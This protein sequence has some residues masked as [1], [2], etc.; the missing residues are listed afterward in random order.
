MKF[1]YLFSTLVVFLSVLITTLNPFIAN[2]T[3]AYDNLVQN[4]PT[5]S[6]ISQDGTQNISVSVDGDLPWYELIRSKAQGY[7]DARCGDARI[8][9]MNTALSG[10]GS[11]YAI[12]ITDSTGT[13]SNG[14]AYVYFGWLEAPYTP[15][16]W[17]FET[18][19][20]V[21]SL[22]LGSHTGGLMR[23]NN[24]GSY[25]WGCDYP[26]SFSISSPADNV[27]FYQ[28]TFPI[29]YPDGYEGIEIVGDTPITPDAR[30]IV[31]PGM[32]VIVSDNGSSDDTSKVKLIFA[33]SWSDFL[34]QNGLS[35][36]DYSIFT[37]TDMEDNVIVADR[38]WGPTG[39]DWNALPLGDYKARLDVIYT[40]EGINSIYEFRTTEVWFAVNNT[41]YTML[42]N[43]NEGKYCTV[44]N[45]YEWNCTI[46][47]P[48][49]EPSLIDGEPEVW[50]ESE[51]V[52]PEFPWV[53]LGN[54]VNN[55]L[56]YLGEYL[57]INGPSITPG[58][59]PFFQFDTNTFGLTAILTAPITILNN[60]ATS[61]YTC[62]TVN[63]PLP[64]IGGDLPLPCMQSYYTTYM[65]GLYTVW[66]TVINGIVA[67]YVIV[68]LLKMVKDAKDPQ[69]DQVE[70]LKL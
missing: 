58:A 17:T 9:Q 6:L 67:Y 5:L 21:P 2:A 3:S 33:D 20:T 4:T 22:N 54:C 7:A 47:Q 28:N 1:K 53:N 42:Y 59:S 35:P 57:G 48:G 68:G 31:Y 69:K 12:Q 43:S 56:H 62:N 11:F 55:A 60:L 40:D 37:L 30:E 52:L 10:A 39:C 66:Q 50:T 70:V 46:P 34:N 24:D 38:C 23:V 63:L 25:Y 18:P 15:P 64:F 13:D 29:D 65:G 49:D 14:Q 36:P 26:S 44:R 16:T 27:Y 51:C 61:E 8:D 19:S 32:S 45:G 41:S